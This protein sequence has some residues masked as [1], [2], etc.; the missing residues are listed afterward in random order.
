MELE[1]DNQERKM[2]RESKR[3][4]ESFGEMDGLG[5][6]VRFEF[7]VVVFLF[8]LFYTFSLLFHILL[9]SLSD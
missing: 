2:A 4:R 8:Q 9:Y 3:L 7:T 5:E 1:L 6:E